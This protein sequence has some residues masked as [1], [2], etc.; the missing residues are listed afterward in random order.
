[1]LFATL[2]DLTRPYTVLEAWAYDAV[3]APATTSLVDGVLDGYLR[4]LAPRARLLDVG[5]GGGQLLTRLSERRPD[6]EL[7][8][9]DLSP[10][11]IARG[12]IRARGRGIAFVEGSALALPFDDA[13]FDAVVSVASLKHWPDAAAGLRE[14]AR[15]LRPGGRLVVGEADRGCRLDDAEAFVSRARIPPAL[16]PV[17]LAAFRTWV[18]GRSMNV[19]EAR[20]LAEPLGLDALEVRAVPGT[21][22]LVIAGRRR[23]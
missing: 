1:M 3:V 23:R 11:Q 17:A 5:C 14:C 15:V 18:A 21:P 10:A 13:S 2:R 9:V 7:T 19:A 6:L 22:A 16:R 4:E 8:G 20:T 12:R